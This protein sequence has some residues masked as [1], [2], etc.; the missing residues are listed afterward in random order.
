[1]V[2]WLTKIHFMQFLYSN[3]K[4]QELYLV[5][6]T[7]EKPIQ[8]TRYNQNSLKGKNVIKPKV[9][10]FKKNGITIKGF[11]LLPKDY[12]GKKKFKAILDIHG[13]P[14]TVYG[15]VYYHEMQYWASLGYVVFFFK[16]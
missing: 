11:V 6:M 5:D 12:D 7:N 10:T 16:S 4:L 8:K 3:K 9:L 1:M 13:G 15:Q 2:L 14:K